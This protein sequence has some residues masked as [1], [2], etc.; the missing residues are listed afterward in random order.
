MKNLLLTVAFFASLTTFSQ[1]TNES[2]DIGGINRTY[3]QYLPT[4]FDSATESL[5]VVFCLHGL[6]DVSTNIANIGF[7]YISD[8][9][10]FIVVYPQ[11]LLNTFSQTSWANGTAFLSS[12]ANDMGLFHALIDE[13][14]LNYNADPARIYVSGFSMGSIMSYK[15]AC[16]M[17]D[18]VAAIGAMSGTMSTDDI[19]NCVPSYKTPVIH[20]H[21][22]ADG[23]VPY[24]AGALPS[25]S[26]V[27]QT[28]DF[29]INEH[30]CATTSDSTQ[31]PD[32]AADGFTVDRFLYQ[33][34]TPANSLEFWRINGGDHQYFYQPTNDFTEAIEIWRFFSQWTHNNPAP[35][36]IEQ[37]SQNGFV[38]APNPSNGQFEINSKISDQINV[39]SPNGQ[40]VSSLNI[41]QGTSSID[42]KHLDAGLYL[43]KFNSLPNL[44][45]RIIIE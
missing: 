9:A 22:T 37:L 29:W 15:L 38:I 4:G 20:F 41:T 6:G 33:N 10:R 19:T 42:L 43:L 40:L 21:G 32:L 39:Y 17:N 25:L 23:T 31:I 11:G 13:M 2:I 26:L 28:L 35:A 36:G 45:E 44:S 3:V 27:P 18:R 1:Q 30:S 12:T 16:E 34:C 7:N 5:P 8:T 14:V 24:N